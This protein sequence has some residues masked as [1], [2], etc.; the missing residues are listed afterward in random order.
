MAYEC[1]LCKVRP[2]FLNFDNSQILDIR[3]F[4]RTLKSFQIGDMAL[5][6]V[7]LSYHLSEYPTYGHLRPGFPRNDVHLLFGHGVKVIQRGGAH[8][9]TVLQH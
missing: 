9:F 3:L 4:A 7:D 8:I 5:V 2:E 6:L 1:R